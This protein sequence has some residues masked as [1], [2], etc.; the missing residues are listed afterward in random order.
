MRIVCLQVVLAV[1]L[2]FGLCA[3]GSD[4]AKEDCD[5]IVIACVSD[6]VVMTGDTVVL[7]GSANIQTASGD[8]CFFEQDPLIYEWKQFFGPVVAIEDKYEQVASFVPNEVG[9]H[10]FHFHATEL[11]TGVTK[12]C[13]V[14]VAVSSN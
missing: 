9:E 6:L 8:M 3:C 4:E 10:V 7:R 1:V 12:A 5:T 2:S 13:T 11:T 14:R